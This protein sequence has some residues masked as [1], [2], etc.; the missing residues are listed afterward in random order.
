MKK[1]VKPTPVQKL[2][3]L[4]M[5]ILWTSAFMWLIP[6]LRGIFA[7]GYEDTYSE[8]VWDLPLW[9]VLVIAALHLVGGV[10]MIWSAGHFIEGWIARRGL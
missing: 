3:I 6:E 9:L 8:W 2:M 5:G 4:Y 1:Q 10:L 7:R